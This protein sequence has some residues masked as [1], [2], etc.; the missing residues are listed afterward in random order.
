MQERYEGIKD[1]NINKKVNEIYS[2]LAGLIDSQQ[3]LNEKMI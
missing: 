1:I 2:D 3:D